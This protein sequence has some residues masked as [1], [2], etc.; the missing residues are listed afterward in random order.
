MEIN[1]FVFKK[2]SLLK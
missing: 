1:L 2:I